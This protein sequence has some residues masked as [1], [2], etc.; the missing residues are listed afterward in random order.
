MN[1]LTF[2]P[3]KDFNGVTK[4]IL[5]CTLNLT[6]EEMIDALRHESILIHDRYYKVPERML[7]HCLI[8]EQF[9][10]TNLELELIKE[11]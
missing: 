2:N 4:T 1:Q 8:N 6:K 11:L 9:G 10:D 7:L 3:P 5:Y